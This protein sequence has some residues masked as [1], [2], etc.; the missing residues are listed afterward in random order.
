MKPYP[1]SMGSAEQ[2]EE[3]VDGGIEMMSESEDEDEDQLAER[4]KIERYGT[5]TAKLR[6]VSRKRIEELKSLLLEVFG[7][8]RH[9]TR[10]LGIGLSM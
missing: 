3:K 7:Q 10:S 2:E 6:T 1:G 9:L 8:K 5:V 4:L